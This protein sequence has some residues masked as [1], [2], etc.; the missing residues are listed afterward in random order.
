MVFPLH[1]P[2]K[3]VILAKAFGLRTLMAAGRE[4]LYQNLLSPETAEALLPHVFDKP[5]DLLELLS[6]DTTDQPFL[7]ELRPDTRDYLG[8]TVLMKLI[9]YK[10]F[11]TNSDAGFASRALRFLIDRGNVNAVDALG[12]TALIKAVR[13]EDLEA[14]RL[15]LHKGANVVHT[16]NRGMSAFDYARGNPAIEQLL[17]AKD[18]SLKQIAS[19]QPDEERVKL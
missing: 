5:D 19:Q 12:E 8:A 11:Y 17:S 10:N 13:M 2:V 14:I 9:E 6:S 3:A 7:Y 1:D 16:D 15:L 18:A 4:R